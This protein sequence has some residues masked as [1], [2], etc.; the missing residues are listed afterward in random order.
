VQQAEDSREVLRQ[1][2]AELVLR[3]PFRQ[4]GQHARQQPF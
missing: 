2:R 3:L 4:Q 1:A